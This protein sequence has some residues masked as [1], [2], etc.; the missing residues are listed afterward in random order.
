MKRLRINVIISA[1]LLTL[2]VNPA[3]VSQNIPPSPTTSIAPQVRLRLIVTD[4][5]DHS[6]DE[7]RKEDIRVFEEKVEQTILSLDRDQRPIDFGIAI[8][9]SGSFKQL[10]APALSAVQVIIQRKRPTDEVFLERFISND[11]METVQ[12]FTANE[13]LLLAGLKKIRIEGGQSAVIDALYIAVDHTAKHQQ[14]D[15]RKAVILISDGEDRASYY[16]R[17]DLLKLL[18]LTNIQV[19]VIGIV[20]LL[21]ENAGLQ[22]PSQRERAEQFLRSVTEESGGRLFLPK[23]TDDLSKAIDEIVHDLDGQFVVGYQSTDSSRKADYRRVDVKIIEAPGKEKAHVIT[24]RGYYAI[25]PKS[26]SK[27][28]DKKSP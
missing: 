20:T 26:D 23:N 12:E 18:R 21:E 9:S 22:R 19:F 2:V 13:A 6:I 5:S 16:K 3:F 24:P 25:T 8:D 14:N 7:I 17:E 27:T 4:K 1:T 15:R 28:N 11:K 10:M